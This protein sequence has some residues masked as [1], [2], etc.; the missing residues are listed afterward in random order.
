M[1]KNT[2]IEIELPWQFKG[3]LMGVA[4]A[5]AAFTVCLGGAIL[6]VIVNDSLRAVFAGFDNSTQP[7]LS[8]AMFWPLPLLAF[9]ILSICFYS[10]FRRT[11]IRRLAML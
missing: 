4:V 5:A 11:L 1:R 6:E 8:F 10:A 2:N 9:G 3:F 7:A